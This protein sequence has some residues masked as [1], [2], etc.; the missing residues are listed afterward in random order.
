M[1]TINLRVKRTSYVNPDNGYVVLKGEDGR[2][3]TTAVGY[4]PEALDGGKLEG[5][6]FE[7]DGQW[8]MSK[9]GRQ[10]AFTA[11]RLTTNQLFYFLAK[12]VKGLGDKLA[13]RLLDHYGEKKLISILE[14]E[15]E[16]LLEFKGI[17][18]K[19]LNQIKSS[20]E[21]QKN[22]RALSEFLLPHGITPNLLVR[23]FNA[24]GTEANKKI[25]DNPYSL[26]DIRGV[27]F[28]TADS[29][30]QKLG[31]TFASSHR[32]EAAIYH[33]LL[34]AGD[35]DGHTYLTPE[36]LH[37]K[38]SELLDDGERKL[39]PTT[40]EQAI[41]TMQKQDKLV[42]DKDQRI[43][44]KAFHFM[45]SSLETFFR[46]R[47][48]ERF[49]PLAEIENIN[50][51]INEKQKRL[52]FTLAP[53]QPASAASMRSRAMPEPVNQQSPKPSSI[54]SPNIFVTGKRSPVAPLPAWL[55]PES[56][57]SAVTRLTP[58]IPYSN[59]RVTIGLSLI[60]KNPC[61]TKSS[62]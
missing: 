29:I 45:E 2:R 3:L 33:L 16:K 35:Q 52:G 46:N 43:A 26:T 39:E 57:N 40:F 54:S 30:A 11:A 28:K 34:E 24:F 9:F 44:L 41:R 20:W 18:E 48:K 49:T 59:T 51:F 1:E 61:P 23:I 7:L 60:V 38:L 14:K 36:T 50:H 55:R 15:P 53:E 31:I 17:K 62:F 10:F 22:L 37:L 4:L 13:Q 8:E 6:D 56:A 5:S 25:H 42:V 12:V 27:G 19:K 21:K 32:I 58:S 47:S